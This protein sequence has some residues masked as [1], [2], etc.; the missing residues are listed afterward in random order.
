VFDDWF[1]TVHAMAAEEPKSW[2]ELIQVQRFSNDFHDDEQYVPELGKEW[3]SPDEMREREEQDKRRH[4]TPTNTMQVAPPQR[5]QV[6]VLPEMNPS[7]A[8]VPMLVP[9]VEPATHKE[10]IAAPGDSDEE[11]VT[12]TRRST[13]ERRAPE[14]FTQNKECGYK[15]NPITMRLHIKATQFQVETVAV[16]AKR[17]IQA[18]VHR[19]RQ[20]YDY[21]Y[22]YALLMDPEY[23]VMTGQLPDVM[24][25]CP[26]LFKSKTK[27]PD[28]PMLHEALAGPHQEEFLKAM[29]NEIKE[30]EEH[31]TW[32]VVKRSRLP[33]GAN[34]LLS[35]WALRIKRFP[36]GRVRKYKA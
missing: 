12:E 34:V 8:E 6:Q 10:E 5:E 9:V 36:D 29:R 33:E 32:T 2:Q 19:T 4:D 28:T 18:A 24:A 16:W 20:V 25:Q 15:L 23:G 1:E 26:Q 11:E 35:T 3:L 22:V 14:R 17:M 13:R 21:N 31:D 30:L 7:T 27:D